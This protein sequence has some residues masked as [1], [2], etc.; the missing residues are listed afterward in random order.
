MADRFVWC[1]V[2][3]VTLARSIPRALSVLWRTTLFIAAASFVALSG[4]G[5]RAR[6]EERR[7][8]FAHV[9]VVDVERGVVRDDQTVVVAGNRVAEVEA[10]DRVTLPPGA[11][12][13]DARGRFLIPGLWDMHA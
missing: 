12:V 8:A 13:I 4:L 7:F 9:S 2:N 5:G 1:F 10:A 6:S 3:S 11:Q